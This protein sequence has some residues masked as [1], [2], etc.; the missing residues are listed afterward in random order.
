MFGESLY[1]K[2]LNI[3]IRFLVV[4]IIVSAILSFT[5]R[6]FVPFFDLPAENDF[7]DLLT[8]LGIWAIAILVALLNEIR[9]HRK[10]KKIS[11]QPNHL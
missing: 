5:C 9:I 2:I 11:S 8:G 6:T 3:I 1:M 7:E 4:T 10:N